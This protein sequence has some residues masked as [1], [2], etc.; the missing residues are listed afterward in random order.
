MTQK[1]VA[2]ET[3]S[4]FCKLPVSAMSVDEAYEEMMKSLPAQS[5]PATEEAAKVKPGDDV[6]SFM[7]GLAAKFFLLR[8]DITTGTAG[9]EFF[10]GF[11]EKSDYTPWFRWCKEQTPP[12]KYKVS[13][14]KWYKIFGNMVQARNNRK[15]KPEPEASVPNKVAKVAAV[16]VAEDPVGVESATGIH[17]QV[18]DLIEANE[19]L[20]TELK[21]IA[22]E[23][24][25]M[26]TRLD[27]A[28]RVTH[29]KAIQR[30]EKLNDRISRLE[31]SWGKS[32]LTAAT[33]VLPKT[34]RTLKPKK[35]TVEKVVEKVTAYRLLP[36]TASY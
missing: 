21:R 3:G 20:Q 6:T 18:A 12:L 16:A 26:E 1:S 13:E 29:N 28:N 9:S 27:D 4:F 34:R 23:L 5:N 35:K 24:K 19:E 8:G 10:L 32:R 36:V 30:D 33:K 11:L 2:A 17:R 31:A 15:R 7:Q 25:Y 14:D 22:Q